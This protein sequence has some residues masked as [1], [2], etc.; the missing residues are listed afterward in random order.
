MN[1][2][3]RSNSHYVLFAPKIWGK[4]V[5]TEQSLFPRREVNF[6]FFYDP[7]WRSLKAAPQN[8]SCNRASI[9]FPWN[10]TEGMAP[11]RNVGHSHCQH[12]KISD[13]ISRLYK[14]FLEKLKQ[15]FRPISYYNEK[16]I[17]LYICI[18]PASVSFIM[19]SCI[20]FTPCSSKRHAVAQL[21]EALSYKSEGPGFDSRWEFFIDII[22]PAALWPWGWLSL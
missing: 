8:N 7:K 9:Q 17:S 22:L 2:L 1:Y 14:N 5:S 12:R 13:Y 6:E 16:F 15:D 11:V 19:K 20:I 21:V 3:F 4:S 10:S 18:I